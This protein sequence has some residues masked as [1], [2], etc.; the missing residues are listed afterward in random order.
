MRK[1]LGSMKKKL[2]AGT[3]VFGSAVAL[4]ASA[5]A[6][7]IDTSTIV[8]YATAAGAAVATV[9]IAILGVKYGKKVYQWLSPS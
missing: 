5:A 9:G 6:G 2:V 8:A 4:N 1:F 7:D 3:A